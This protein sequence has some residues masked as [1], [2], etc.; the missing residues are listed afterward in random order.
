MRG[1]AG[2][3]GYA[4]RTVAGPPEV[5]AGSSY[6]AVAQGGPT[7]SPDVDAL[8]R[9]ALARAR[10]VS[11]DELGARIVRITG[12]I[13]AAEYEQ[14]VLIAAF[15]EREGWAESGHRDCAHWLAFHTGLERNACRERVRTA[16]ALVG[17]PAT[18]AA[19]A[20]G[21]LSFTK[22]RELTRVATAENEAALVN[23][24]LHATADATRQFLRGWKR[25]GRLEE[26][27]VARRQQEE[28]RATVYPL[29]S[30]MYRL[31]ADLPP[32]AGALV[33]KVLECFAH[34]MHGTDTSVTGKQRFADALVRALEVAMAVGPEAAPVSGSRAGRYT[35]FL[36]VD[37]ATLSADGEPEKSHL[38]DNT[39]VSAETSRRI[40]CD[41]A[42]VA[43]LKDEEGNTL[44]AGRK[45]RTIPPAIRRVLEERDGGCRFP[46]CGRRLTDA[47]HIQHWA[48]GGETKADNL[49]LLCRHHRMLVHEGGFRVER[50][51]RGK[52][53]F[54]NRADLPL[55][56][57][58]DAVA[59]GE[60]MAASL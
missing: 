57:R 1:I 42:M 23:Y 51:E 48:E 28:R 45:T 58:P 13:Q 59:L 44:S 41:A 31:S 29:P 17:L 47:H 24:A 19:M 26:A 32:D 37:P 4:E 25:W 10:S 18:S 8:V 55:L 53:R 56:E 40:T 54:F 5:T 27:E 60:A 6:A 36:H 20:R 2:Q 46:G 3:V 39:R 50:A 9:A 49:V 22:V 16:R 12:E 15:D 34:A 43:L 21:E 7:R 30:G 33:M 35:V 38:Q 52:L 14:L 11:L